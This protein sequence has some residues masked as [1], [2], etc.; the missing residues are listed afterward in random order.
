MV[1]LATRREVERRANGRCEYGGFPSAFAE[2]R[3]HVGHGISEQH[4]G[5]SHAET[6]AFA[7]FPCNVYKGPNLSSVDPISGDVVRLFNP[8]RDRWLDHFEWN[9]AWVKGRTPMGRATLVL[10]RMNDL[11]A[12]AARQ[13]LMED[14]VF[15]PS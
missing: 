7:C 13:S 8:R 4:G 2:A 6:L 9:G 14:G 1:P 3:F 10:L 15:F 5:K 12:V 11:Y